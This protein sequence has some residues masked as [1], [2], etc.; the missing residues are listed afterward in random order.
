MKKIFKLS[1]ALLCVLIFS[2]FCQSWLPVQKEKRE[3]YQLTI[4]H[5]GTSDQE[6]IIENYLKNAL[7]P[8][9]HKMNTKNIGVFKNRFNDT[10]SDKTV[11]VLMPIS[12]LDE[13]TKVASRLSA[14]KTYQ[15]AGT[16][17]LKSVY[18]SPP[19]ARIETILLQAFSLAPKLRTPALNGP[20]KDRIYE[21]R[22]YESATEEIFKNKVHMFNEG[23]EIGLFK[24]LNFN[25]AFYGEVLAG[26]KMPNL[27]YMTCHENK[28]ARDA[29]WKSFGAD[30]Y[31]KKL[32]SMPEYQHN[33][34][35]ID[36]SFL[37]PAE[38]SDY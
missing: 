8:A 33:V 34:S 32:S 38:Y 28:Q 23:D 12:S 22:S 7:L 11:Y 9:L 30:P 19:Y 37:Y 13:I 6:N 21:L 15:A 3:F 24:R 18:S 1:S 17:Y 4:Y 35:H 2:F 36:I 27:M 25:A 31:W 16:G 26:S 14:D 10:L 20:R 29:N 5:F